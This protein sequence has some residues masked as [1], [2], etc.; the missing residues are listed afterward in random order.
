MVDPRAGMAICGFITS[1]VCSD[2]TV[3]NNLIAGTSF[4]GVAAPGHDCNDAADSTFKNNVIHSVDGVGVTFF[5]N[6]NLAKSGT[7]YEG[8]YTTVYKATQAGV[9]TYYSTKAVQLNNL[10]LIDNGFGALL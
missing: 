4:Y 2:I 5:P 3:T 1:D 7:C 9:F 6:P 10:V 8:S